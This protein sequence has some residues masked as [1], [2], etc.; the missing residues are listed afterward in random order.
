MSFY[1]ASPASSNMSS[2]TYTYVP[3]NTPPPMGPVLNCPF[4][5]KPVVV[6]S[7]RAGL[8]E[9]MKLCHPMEYAKQNQEAAV[10]TTEAL[11]KS[12]AVVGTT[13]RNHTLSI[14]PSCPACKTRVPVTNCSDFGLHVL[15][16]TGQLNAITDNMTGSKV[17]MSQ[18]LG[19]TPHVIPSILQQVVGVAQHR[20]AP[21]Q[22]SAD[23]IDG[24]HTSVCGVLVRP[25]EKRVNS[26]MAGDPPV[27]VPQHSATRIVHTPSPF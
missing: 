8:R 19:A 5:Q 24:T 22:S 1:S 26:Y 2:N 10:G 23:E 12:A 11:E 7:K 18:F 27:S 25:A 6:K 16:C 13:L 21:L 15:A 4:C 17:V 3:N 9:H 14:P 20:L